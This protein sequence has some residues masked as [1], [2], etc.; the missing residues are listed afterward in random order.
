MANYILPVATE[1]T[2]VGDNI[3]EGIDITQDGVL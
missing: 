2:L 3:G 1:T